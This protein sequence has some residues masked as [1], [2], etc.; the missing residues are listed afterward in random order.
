ML[1][2]ENFNLLLFEWK[3]ESR[4]KLRRVH[5]LS[6][7]IISLSSCSST[8][9]CHLFDVTSNK[10]HYFHEVKL[11]HSCYLIITSETFRKT[12]FENSFRYI[13]DPPTEFK[14]YVILSS[15]VYLLEESTHSKIDTC[16]RI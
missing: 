6:V 13:A 15:I 12:F 3:N 9:L 16:C 14:K 7:F 2:G 8:T 5:F 10:R 11:C 1:I 4:V